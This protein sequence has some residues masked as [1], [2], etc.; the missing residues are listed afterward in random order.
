M[1]LRLLPVLLALAAVAATAHAADGPTCEDV[2]TQPLR[3]HVGYSRELIR[4]AGSVHME[5]D[6]V[7]PD[8]TVVENGIFVYVEYAGEPG[9]V[10]FRLTPFDADGNAG[11]PRVVSYDAGP[12]AN[13]PPRCSARPASVALGG[14]DRVDGN[15]H[16]D[17]VDHL[18]ITAATPPH[19]GSVG[20]IRTDPPFGVYGTDFHVPYTAP[21]AADLPAT[22]TFGVQAGDGHGGQAEVM[23]TVTLEPF[24][25]TPTP[26]PSPSPSPSPAEIA[27]ATPTAA[28]VVRATLAGR[29]R[30]TVRRGAFT[31]MLSPGPAGC[32]VKV[33]ASGAKRRRVVIASGAAAAGGGKVTV[34]LNRAGRRLVA[35]RAIRVTAVLIPEGD[36]PA[37]SYRLTLKPR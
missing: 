3:T 12:D 33:Y 26:S 24:V 35:R 16:D 25:P 2:P 23:A 15:C 20:A 6:Q 34:R 13:R 36:A 27:T 9:P 18:T 30:R 5:F 4:C 28:P 21:D 29:R 31:V 7:S 22:D 32:A 14:T 11:T 10:S 19:L 17:E 37:S 1:R 8:L